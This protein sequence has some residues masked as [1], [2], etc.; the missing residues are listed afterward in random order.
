MSDLTQIQKDNRHVC[1]WDDPSLDFSDLCI[2][3]VQVS[4]RVMKQEKSWEVE[5]GLKRVRQQNM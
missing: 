3:V 2:P 4:V 1:S 5:D